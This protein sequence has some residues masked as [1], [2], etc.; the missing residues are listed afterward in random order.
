[1]ALSSSIAF[2]LTADPSNMRMFRVTSR[3]L[4]SVQINCIE[5]SF[6]VSIRSSTVLLQSL[7]SGRMVEPGNFFN[8]AVANAIQMDLSPG[9][10]PSLSLKR[11]IRISSQ[12]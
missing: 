7:D 5:R 11:E 6:L 3:F 8:H 2:E 4:E 12:R 1:M 9:N 10:I